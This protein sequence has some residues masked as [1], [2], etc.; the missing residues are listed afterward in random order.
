MGGC[1]GEGPLRKKAWEALTAS[2]QQECW[3]GGDSLDLCSSS[4]CFHSNQKVTGSHRLHWLVAKVLARLLSVSYEP[5]S[6]WG[7]LV[8]PEMAS[9]TIPSV[10]R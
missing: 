6:P 5:S 4:Q 3:P 1:Q 9:D 10:F 8:G 2:P 7:S